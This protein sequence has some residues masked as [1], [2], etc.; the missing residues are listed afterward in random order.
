M[1]KIC[2]KIN[3]EKFL[4]NWYRMPLRLCPIQVVQI[5]EVIRTTEV[6]VMW[7]LDSPKQE[8]FK[9]AQKLNGSI[10]F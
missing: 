2:V 10:T 7:R 8:V 3:L 9:I 5:N 6:K 4:S 1:Y